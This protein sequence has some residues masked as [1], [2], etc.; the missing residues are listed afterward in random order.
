MARALDR[1]GLRWARNP[2]RSGFGIPLISIG[3]TDTFYPDV[4]IWTDER[5]ICL[6]T[7]GGH[8][9][10]ETARRKLLRI[11]PAKVG[12]RLDVQFVSPGKFDDAMVALDSDGFSQWFLRDDGQIAARY[13][14][15][16]DMLV[17]APV[18][19]SKS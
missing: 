17:A 19:D 12:P 10:D 15:D 18:D 9:V 8:L 11:K 14:E 1:T 16:L 2:S 3:P 5:V 4:L 13:F 7:K 6:D